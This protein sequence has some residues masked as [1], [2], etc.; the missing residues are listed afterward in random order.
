M[1]LFR[2]TPL[3][4]G[5]RYGAIFQGHWN[6]Y[7]SST[8]DQIGQKN[9]SVNSTLI[10]SSPNPQIVL[11]AARLMGIKAVASGLGFVYASKRLL[12]LP[13]VQ[14]VL[15]N[16]EFAPSSM[17][18]VCKVFLDMPQTHL[19][20][21]FLL[22]AMVTKALASGIAR[23]TVT[24]I[25]RIE[26]GSDEN[27]E[28][29]RPNILPFTKSVTIHPRSNVYC[30]DAT[31]TMISFRL[32]LPSGR[33]INQYLFPISGQWK[34]DDYDF[35]R[36]LVYGDYF[37]DEQS[38]PVDVDLIAIEGFG[39]Y[40][41]AQFADPMSDARL[42]L[43]PPPGAKDNKEAHMLAVSGKPLPPSPIEDTPFLH[44]EGSVWATF[45]VPERPSMEEK[46]KIEY[47]RRMLETVKL[48]PD[49]EIGGASEHQKFLF[50]Q[51]PVASIAA[52]ANMMG[53]GT[54][55]PIENLKHEKSIP[56]QSTEGDESAPHPEKL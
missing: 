54:L 45:N 15:A 21:G 13:K 5:V 18:E 9:D 12:D 29:T 53:D 14:S 41:P 33:E 25:R 22:F 43:P 20:C 49:V 30:A 37:R 46:R 47:H 51:K 28:I 8:T 56:P 42:T 7:L 35:L 23:R 39:H 11:T 38:P 4:K 44:A 32:R 50:G 27:I 48:G 17:Y 52:P 2:L 26:H 31:K 3:S 34:T 10:Y 19:A 40:R 36:I 6:R 16:A 24:Q 55:R 1:S